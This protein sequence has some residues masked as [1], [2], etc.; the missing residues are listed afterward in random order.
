MSTYLSERCCEGSSFNEVLKRGQFTGPH[1]CSV[2]REL[3]EKK[4]N[5][6]LTSVEAAA[7]DGIGDGELTVVVL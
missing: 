3:I 6:H 7:Y 2:G 1:S 5:K 4:E